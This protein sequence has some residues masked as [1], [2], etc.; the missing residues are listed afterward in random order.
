MLTENQNRIIADLSVEFNELNKKSPTQSNK[1]GYSLIN[2]D[3]LLDKTRRENEFKAKVEEDICIWNAKKDA[4]VDRLLTLFRKDLPNLSIHRQGKI[5]G[6]YDGSSIIIC[7]HGKEMAHYESLIWI[8]VSY[9]T[10][11]KSDEFNNWDK[12]GEALR[13]RYECANYYPSI[14]ELIEKSQFL[15]DL[16]KKML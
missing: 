11:N 12:F 16:R 1:T 4:E 5:H 7:R 6:K 8:E 14:E 3:A 9:T 13:Y 10:I 15:N 2:V